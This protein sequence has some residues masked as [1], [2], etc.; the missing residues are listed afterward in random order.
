MSLSI[1]RIINLSSSPGNPEP[2]FVKQLSIAHESVD[3]QLFQYYIS[4]DDK[5]QGDKMTKAIGVY[6]PEINSYHY[7]DYDET[8]W[9]AQR[10]HITFSKIRRLGVKSFPGIGAFAFYIFDSEMDYIP[11]FC[12]NTR[13]VIPVHRNHND[14]DLPEGE[15]YYTNEMGN[16]IVNAGSSLLTVLSQI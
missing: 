1:D 13:I 12:G 8:E 16:E 11:I 4:S 5:R 9:G 7:V 10:S 3:G 2:T 6:D 15:L 14:D